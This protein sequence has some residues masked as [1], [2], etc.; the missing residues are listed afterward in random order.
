MANENETDPLAL[1]GMAAS[2]ADPTVA[3]VEPAVDQAALNASAPVDAPKE[4][5]EEKSFGFE[6]A[7]EEADDLPALVRL[8]G[9]GKGRESQYDFASLKAP[10]VSE[11]GKRK[12]SVLFV[13]FTGEGDADKM[14]RSV[15]SAS[16]QQ[17]R[18]NEGTSV[19]YETRSVQENGKF[20]GVK[21][22]RTDARPVEAPKAEAAEPAPAAE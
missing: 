9:G 12:L 4:V 7:T 14:K 20:L 17:N 19:Y 22:Y 2:P 6:Q 13:K 5:A 1:L 11:D 8:G 21:V 15:Q 3:N 18:Q 10:V 16:T